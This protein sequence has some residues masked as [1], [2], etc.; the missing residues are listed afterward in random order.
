M[1]LKKNAK[2]I[3]LLSYSK[4]CKEDVFFKTEEGDVLNL[5]S[6]LSSVLLQSLAHDEALIATGQIV[7]INDE[8]YKVLADF[9]E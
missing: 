3:E 9:L 7:C 2:L 5:K 4:M 6:L 8:D 1:K